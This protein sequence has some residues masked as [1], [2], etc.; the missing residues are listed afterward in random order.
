MPLTP[1]DITI[2]ALLLALLL[3]ASLHTSLKRRSKK[4]ADFFTANRTLGSLLQFFLNFGYMADSNEAANVATE[5]YRQGVA[6]MWIGF[7]A[8]FVT[9]FFYFTPVWFRRSRQ[10]T[11]ADLFTDRFNSKPLAATYA[12]I[13][14]LL[15][16]ALLSLGNLTAYKLAT[17]M[18]VKPPNQCTPAELQSVAQFNELQ[19]LKSKLATPQS[20]PSQTARANVLPP[21]QSSLTPTETERYHQLDSLLARNQISSYISW[22]KPAPDYITYSLLVASYL[23]LGGIH[24]V[25]IIDALQSS[26]LLLVS[27]I[28][29]PLALTKLGGVGGLHQLHTALPSYMFRVFGDSQDAFSEYGP[30]TICALVLNC[31]VGTPSTGGPSNASGKNERAVRIGTLSGAFAKRLLMIAWMFTGLLAAALLPHLSDPDTTWGQL[32]NLLLPSASAGLLG[33]MITGILL[34]HMPNLAYT[35]LSIS[36]LFTRNIYTPLREYISS[37]NTTAH[38]LPPPSVPQCLGAS[39]PPP[40]PP[41]KHSALST[42]HSLLPAKLSTIAALTAATLIPLL[43]T[44]G[45]IPR[46]TNTMTFISFGGATGY[47]LYFW[48]KLTA[49]AI[50]ISMILWLLFIGILPWLL[51]QLP[52]FRQNPRLLLTTAP[53]TAPRP[54][55]TPQQ[56]L[57]NTPETDYLTPRNTPKSSPPIPARSQIL[58]IPPTSYRAYSLF[59]DKIAR[60]DPTNP[61]SPLEGLGRFNLENYLAYQLGLPLQTMTPSQVA[62]IRW[63]ADSLLPF[64]LLMGFSH[65]PHRNKARHADQQKRTAEF[66]DKLRTPIGLTPEKDAQEVALSL[67]NPGRFDHLKLFPNSNWE[68]YI[69]NKTDLTAFLA[70]WLAVGAILALLFAVVNRQ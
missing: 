9:P 59:Y 58:P 21:A 51:P 62:S 2:I 16:T 14:I 68:L 26:L 66:F 34:G 12:A 46:L 4:P 57:Q 19:S 49:P 52:T 11:F 54:P 70:C 22:L 32:S 5:T 31:L 50:W 48:K 24:A 64:L 7:Q 23:L 30:L 13:H 60:M 39:V 47:L 56:P 27:F 41:T 6:G 37:N 55:K 53:Q 61:T 18:L 42:K 33:L 44:G 29:I 35:T 36:A 67:A 63:F 45:M 43:Y 38:P 17:A 1:A 10:T 3:F 28:L 8:L 40:P 25:A 20:P 65:L 15:L 69:W